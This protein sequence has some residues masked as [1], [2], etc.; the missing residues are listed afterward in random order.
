MNRGCFV[1]LIERGQWPQSS[2]CQSPFRNARI[3][4]ALCETPHANIASGDTFDNKSRQLS[5]EHGTREVLILTST[6]PFS[7]STGHPKGTRRRRS[8]NARSVPRILPPSR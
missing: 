8:P 7:P 3:G 1:Q 2:A 6:H 4:E 5:R